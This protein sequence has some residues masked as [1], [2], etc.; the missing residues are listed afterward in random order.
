[1]NTLNKVKNA[2]FPPPAYSEDGRAQWPSRTSFLLASMGGAMGFG[3]MLR[4]P[5]QVYNNSGLQWFIPY[6]IAITCLAIPVLI[7]EISIGQAH[8]SGTVNAFNA[9]DKRLRGVGLG[10]VFTGYIVCVYYVPMLSWVWVYFRSSFQSSPFAWTGRAEDFFYNDVVINR[11]SIPGVISGGSVQSYSSYPNTGVSG[12]LIGW[13]ILSWL[14]VWLCIHKGVSITGRVVY[15]TIGLPI[16]MTIILLGRGVSLENAGRGIKLYFGEW[17]SE[18]LASGQ[19]WQDA[20]GQVFY[21]TGV[22]FG[23]FTAYASYNSQFAS[24]VQDSL[25]ICTSNA[26]YEVTAAFIAFGIVGYLDMMP[27]DSTEPL[28]TYSLGFLTYPV[29]I[30]QMPGAPF[31]AIIFFLTLILLGISSSYAML[32]GL[33]TI[34]CDSEY[35]RR[36]KHV[37]VASVCTV[38]S[39]LM[40]FMF[41]TEFG[42]DLLNAT[43][44]WANNIALLFAAFCECYGST[45]VYRWADVAGQ[46]GLPSF[47]V[48]NS[49]Y[50][51]GLVLGC[52]IAHS[53]SPSAGAGVGFGIFIVC[54]IT[55]LLLAKDPD[56]RAPRFF[57]KNK[58]LNRAWWLFFYSGNQLA[59]DLNVTVATGKA[60]SIPPV[61]GVLLRYVAAPILGIIFSFSYP[62]FT[63]DR[64]GSLE[65][66]GFTVAHLVLLTIIAAFL[67]PR[68][69]DVLVPVE[70]R[71]EGDRAYAPQVLLGAE[72]LRVS[73]GIE[74]G[75]SSGLD[76]GSDKAEHEYESKSEK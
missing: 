49:G 17:H 19:I 67:L 9:L 20:T 12:E 25:I 32:D 39:C 29:A 43:D 63:P 14:I 56:S 40:S 2:M 70:R 68:F 44:R 28:G 53:V 6:L 11:E 7:L 3:N 71:A 15:L 42:Y 34:I 8:R 60:W 30:D 4:Y 16:I 76:S 26:L 52:A 1:M 21:S 38:V 58:F 36:Y 47:A 59:R 73:N 31:F 72:D 74:T 75:T 55:A 48:Y 45:T 65:I 41:C 61:W 35:G 54:T 10:M 22:G 27:S 62:S 13:T 51:G 24:A 50:L 64:S 46:V 23:Y 18:K 37:T 33:V 5:S 69:L 66:W 57:G